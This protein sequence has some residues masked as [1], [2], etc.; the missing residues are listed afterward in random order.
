MGSIANQKDVLT[1]DIPY[2]VRMRPRMLLKYHLTN[3]QLKDPSLLDNRSFIG[4]EW[5][6]SSS[7][8]TFPVYGKINH[9]IKGYNCRLRLLQTQKT[10][11]RSVTSQT[12]AA[13]TLGKLLKQ[14]PRP[15]KL[16]RPG[17]TVND[18]G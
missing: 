15:S 13:M 1:K 11:K 17:R 14:Q 16:T 4:G 3:V 8:D 10:T 12:S 5:V 7:K 18:D 2:E 6:G 9:T